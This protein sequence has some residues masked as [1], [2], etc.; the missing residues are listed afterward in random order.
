VNV[1]Q[2]PA[3][4]FRALRP[5]RHL[6]A[7]GFVDPEILMA[8]VKEPDRGSQNHAP[9]HPEE[10]AAGHRGLHRTLPLETPIDEFWNRE[11]AAVQD[12]SQNPSSN[13]PY[14]FTRAR[15]NLAVRLPGAN[16]QDGAV[17]RSHCGR[18]E[19]R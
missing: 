19:E 12:H 9:D 17:P 2:E 4:E 13:D 7:D 15:S 1:A 10:I 3:P 16:D 8:D 11:L 5:R 18:R 6:N 14:R